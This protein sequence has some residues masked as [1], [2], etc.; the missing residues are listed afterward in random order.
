MNYLPLLLAITS[1]CTPLTAQELPELLQTA[2]E[3]VITVETKKYSY[4]QELTFDADQPWSL[5]LTTTRSG[6]KKGSGDPVT[7]SFNLADIDGRLINYEDDRTEQTV[8]LK[9][10]RK[11]DVIK[12]TD[13]D[14]DVSYDDEVVIWSPEIDHATQL[15][16]AL[17]AAAP[18]AEAAWVAAFQPGATLPELSSWLTKNITGVTTEDGAIDVSWV[19]DG[20]L[21][22]YATLSV[23]DE[24]GERRAYYLSLADVATNSVGLSV[25]GDEV[26]VELGMVGRQAIIRESEAGVITDYV[27]EVEIP[28]AGVDEARYLMQ[29]LTTAVPLAVKVRKA[30]FTEPTN[31]EIAQAHLL[32][33]V[34]RPSLLAEGPVVTLAPGLTPVLTL[35]SGEGDDSE[36]NRFLF[37]YADLNPASVK[38]DAKGEQLYVEVKT[39]RKRDFVQEWEDDEEEGFTDELMVP[40]ADLEAARALEILLPY[41]IEAAAQIPV[42]PEA[43]GWLAGAVAAG[44]TEEVQQSLT[45]GEACKWTLV[46]TED[47]KKASDVTYDF[48]LYNIDA[49]RLEIEAGRRGVEL[50]LQTLKQEKIINVL[51]DGEP[52]FTDELTIRFVD[53]A[54]AKTGLATVRALV[55]A[56][57]E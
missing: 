17:R 2:V 23:T 15:R 6:L 11:L 22:D 31:L 1:L 5:T 37:H 10:K 53:L 32:K 57:S 40:V 42:A 43:F 56:C 34:N 36:E 16:D 13:A 27:D 50:Q 45:E 14:G 4:D 33:A 52:E 39:A 44:S 28:V 21:T 41:V 25:K 51:E 24:D 30:R 9:T 29:V 47:D 49:R 19:P 46:V 3:G 54:S 18:L 12:R 38:I 7:Y 26:T 55:E 48:N 20:D 35:R 8:V